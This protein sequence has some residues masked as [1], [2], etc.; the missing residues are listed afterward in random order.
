VKSI[1]LSNPSLLFNWLPITKGL[2]VPRVFV[3]PTYEYGGAYFRRTTERTVLKDLDVDLKESAVILLP[4]TNADDAATIAHE[5]RHHWQAENCW[6]IQ[7]FKIFDFS[8]HNYDREINRFFKTQP[9]EMD[10]LKFQAKMCPKDDLTNIWID[11][12][13]LV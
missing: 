5:F 13:A 8:F 7:E 11:M 6:P 9:A 10:A 12:L 3:V 1:K 2:S 4:E